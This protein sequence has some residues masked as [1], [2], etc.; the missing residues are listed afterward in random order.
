MARHLLDARAWTSTGTCR[1][2]S[3][4]GRQ[5]FDLQTRITGPV[6]N[7]IWNTPGNGYAEKFKHVIEPTFTIQRVDGDRQLRPDRQAR[8]HGL[9]RR[10][11]RRG[12]PTASTNRLYAKKDDVARDPERDDDA[13]LLHRR[14]RRAVRSAA[15]RAASASPTPTNFS[16]S[17]SR[18][19]ASPTDRLQA[20]FRTDWDSDGPR[21]ADARRQRH[22]QHG[23]LAAA[24]APAGASGASFRTCPAST[25]R[26]R[27]DQL[28][29]RERRPAQRRQPAR[30]QLRVQ[31]RSAARQLPAAAATSRITTRSAAASASSTRP[32]TSRESL[33]TLGVAAGPPL[34]L[35]FTLAGIGTFSNF[36]GAFGGQQG[37]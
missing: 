20:D 16:P 11:R 9:H 35:S 8:R 25:T 24:S 27:A 17:R 28:P 30:R 37:R 33:V 34:Q 12:S 13:E 1:C 32:S 5:Y 14:A 4:I 29:Q 31:L 19:A 18:C 15:T 2:P 6:F 3:R 7:R 36:F 22:A 26:T 10:Q 23:E 21:A